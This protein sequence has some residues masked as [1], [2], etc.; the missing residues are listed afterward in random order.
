[1][2]QAQEKHFEREK[3]RKERFSAYLSLGMQLRAV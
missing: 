2:R 3:C 1:M